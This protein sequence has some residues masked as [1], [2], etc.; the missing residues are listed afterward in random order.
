MK[1]NRDTTREPRDSRQDEADVA[2]I[3]EIEQIIGRKL[4]GDV[5]IARFR[6]ELDDEQDEK[7]EHDG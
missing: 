3:G 4:S 7:D 6:P 5:K 1:P 2:R